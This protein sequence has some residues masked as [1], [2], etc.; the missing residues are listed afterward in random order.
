MEMMR[1]VL[2]T[3]FWLATHVVVITL[4]YSATF[5]AGSAGHRSTSCLGVFTGRRYGH[6]ASASGDSRPC[7]ATRWPKWSMASSAS[8][9]CSASSARCSAASGP[10][11]PGAGSGAGTPRRTARCSSSSGTPSSS[12]PAGA[13]WSRDRGLMNL[14]VF[15][16]IVTSFSWFGVN[17]LGIGL[18]SYGFMDA[19]FKWLH[20]LH[21]QPARDYRRR[22]ACRCTC[23]GVSAR[24]SQRHSTPPARNRPRPNTRR[25]AGLRERHRTHRYGG[26]SPKRTAGTPPPRP[27]RDRP[28]EHHDATQ[29]ARPGDL[30]H[31]EPDD[32]G[33]AGSRR[34]EHAHGDGRQHEHHS[35][36][37]SPRPPARPG[38]QPRAGRGAADSRRDGSPTA[39]VGLSPQRLLRPASSRSA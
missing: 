39:A 1:A 24:V 22:P 35:R 12:T 8:P 2:D 21:R 18:H 36:R 10:T 20:D 14:A 25:T 17:M 11:N 28:G 19:A 30:G 38:S 6:R 34:D 7:L 31:P 4:G 5:V 27:A 3:N 15:G 26:Q 37:A 29:G 13:A 32:Q 23:G 33:H 16:N 9:P